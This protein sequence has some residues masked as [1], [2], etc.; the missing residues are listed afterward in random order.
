MLNLGLKRLKSLL[1]N[2]VSLSLFIDTPKLRF[3]P[4]VRLNVATANTSPFSFNNALPLL[5]GE[6]GAVTC[7]ISPCC[8]SFLN[9]ATIPSETLFSNPKGLLIL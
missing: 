7:I 8:L 2:A 6:I 9:D 3:C 5:P 4:P 1:V